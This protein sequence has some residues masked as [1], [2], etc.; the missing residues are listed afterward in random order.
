[1]SNPFISIENALLKAG[2]FLLG[3]E[4]K[5][6]AIFTAEK[7]VAPDAA[8][9]AVTLFSDVESFISLAAPAAGASGLNFAADS[10]A[11]AAFLKI[12]ADAK[13]FVAVAQ[14]VLTAAE[15]K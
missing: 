14:S 1:M 13:S 11:Y 8:A 15:T 9:A 2:S 7:A 3:L 6:A 12:V 4:E 10:A 5:A